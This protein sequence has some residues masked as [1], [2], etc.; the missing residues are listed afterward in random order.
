MGSMSAAPSGKAL[1]S[2]VPSSSRRTFTA[3]R[4]DFFILGS[5]KAMPS[6]QLK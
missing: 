1:I 5:G 3:L 6:E 4:K 2:G